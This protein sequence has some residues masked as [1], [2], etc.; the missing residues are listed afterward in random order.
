MVKPERVIQEANADVLAWI[1]AMKIDQTNHIPITNR[2]FVLS[3]T[4][5]WQ[6]PSSTTYKCN[7]DA[8]FLYSNHQAQAGWI[9]RDYNGIPHYWGSMTLGWTETPLEAEAKALL[10]AM[11]QAWLMGFES[12]SFEGDNQFLI[13]LI[14][15]KTTDVYI[16]N[17]CHDILHWSPRFLTCSFRHMKRSNNVPADI[18]SKKD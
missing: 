17:I 9:I 12:I 6:R 7:F 8:S 2:V 16:E 10:V 15:G 5:T 11:Q 13:D 4:Y 14:Q 1:A 3:Q 18:L